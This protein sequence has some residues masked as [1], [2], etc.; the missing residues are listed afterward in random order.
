MV[1]RFARRVGALALPLAWLPAAHAQ[2]PLDDVVEITPGAEIVREVA[3]SNPLVA[4]ATAWRGAP[5][6]AA[7]GTLP[8]GAEPE[9]GVL[10]ELVCLGADQTAGGGAPDAGAA[11]DYTR[12]AFARLWSA[13]APGGMFAFFA[14]DEPLFARG[15]LQMAD[16]REA[17]GTAWSAD[18]FALRLPPASTLPYRWGLVVSKGPL[19][20]E[21]AARLD[22][23]QR[24]LPLLAL[25]GPGVEPRSYWG[26]AA[27]MD[28]RAARDHLRRELSRRAGGW[29]DLSAA[30]TQRPGFFDLDPGAPAPVRAA[31]GIAIFAL[32]AA[33]LLPLPERRRAGSPATTPWPLPLLLAG[34]AACAAAALLGA[35]AIGG[36]AFALG[37]GA[38]AD[39]A[40]VG[41][42]VAAGAALGARLARRA[43]GVTGAALAGV[44]V[45]AAWHAG[46][47][48][49]L[50]AAG[51]GALRAA[52]LALAGASL[53]M[54]AARAFVPAR[55]AL[56]A[57]VPEG[58]AVA[59]AVTVLAL[60]AAAASAPW[61]VDWRG[62]PAL[63][64]AAAGCFALGAAGAAALT[65]SSGS[66]RS[67]PR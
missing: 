20:P 16:L 43:G 42:G 4:V 46:L 57:L 44:A 29:L 21:A 9:P 13:V 33:L 66:A 52:L 22:A 2:D 19:E 39:A 37:G 61:L 8:S 11:R 59:F 1:R 51:R 49:L 5:T 34:P 63:W 50:E 67:S 27:A 3:A 15:V 6:I 47:G 48:P 64:T 54:P 25:F 26:E 45:A 28:A 30:T 18:A 41:A 40:C 17:E 23:L 31:A 56:A 14:A 7:A 38:A 36:R 65:A 60:A 32:L 62:Y 58:R 12:E 10:Y 55:A 35:A 24:R 53:A